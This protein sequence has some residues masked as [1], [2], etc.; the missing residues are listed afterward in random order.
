MVERIKMIKEISK[1]HFN[2]NFDIDKYNQEAVLKI[3]QYAN[4]EKLAESDDFKLS[5]GILLCGGNGTGKTLLMLI[6]AEYLRCLNKRSFQV[7]LAESIVQIFAA[8]GAVGIDP[9]LLNPKIN[10][11]GFYENK[12]F[13]FCI[14]DLGLEKDSVM[15][16]GARE[17]VIQK[18][19]LARYDVFKQGIMPFATS[20]LNTDELRKKYGERIYSRMREMFNILILRGEDR[21]K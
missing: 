12:P 17:E 4:S 21:R 2:C 15:H 7:Y 11:F 14:D 19:L 13:Q 10:S 5:K 1:K 8:R 3:I 20:N 16:F 9:F 6:L 18:V